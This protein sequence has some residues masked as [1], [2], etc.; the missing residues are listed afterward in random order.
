MSIHSSHARESLSQGH[1]RPETLSR[2]STGL[3]IE[4]PEPEEEP[5]AK[6]TP[7]A[8]I[9]DT[10]LQIVRWLG[11]GG[12][13]A[14]FEVRHL[15]IDRHFAIKLLHQS[16]SVA[17][18]RRFRREAK[19]IGNLG[20]P[21]IVEVFDF[22]EL[23]D[24]RLMYLM[25]LVEGRSLHEHQREIGALPLAAVI[26]LARQLCKGL[27]DA[28]GRG[29]IHRDIKPEN[30]M[31][32]TDADGRERVKIVDFGLAGLLAEPNESS[33]AGTPTYMS[34][35]QCKGEPADARTDLYSLGVT[36]YELACGRLPFTG[37]TERQL[38]EAHVYQQPE[39]PSAKLGD[40]SRALPAA[41]DELVLRCMAKDP[42]D[43]FANAAE[44]EAALIELQIGRR[45]RTD[46]DELPAPKVDEKRRQRLEQ[47]LTLL[48]EDAQRSRRKR[49]F[50]GAALA[51]LVGLSAAV[52]WIAGAESR[53]EAA[54]QLEAELHALREQ[55][56]E[57]AQAGR[58]IY[59]LVEQPEDETAYRLLQKLEAL[60][61]PQALEMGRQLRSEI[62][63][64]LVRLGDAYWNREGGESYAREYYA[65][66]QLF[67][68]DEPHA[69]QRSGLSPARAEILGERAATGEFE[70]YELEAAEPLVALAATDEQ[71]VIAALDALDTSRLS[72]TNA[73]AID[74]LRGVD[75]NDQDR[76]MLAVRHGGAPI[77]GEPISS[78]DAATA[79]EPAPAN[80]AHDDAKPEPI[81]GRDRS[82]AKTLVTSGKAAYQTGD[83][84][85]AKRA[86]H[87]ALAADGSNLEAL[88]G[89][90]RIHFDRGDFKDALT[91]AKKALT[92]R[93][94]RGDL[95]LYV[96]DSC[97]KVLDYGCARSHY[98][99]AAEAGDSRAPARLRMLDD[100]L[101]GSKGS[102]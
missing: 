66:A 18:A 26:G 37:S 95:N 60:G 84:D 45:L 69:R 47:G 29:V 98:Q 38:R 61:S 85:E 40:E 62:A 56:R 43:R 16:Q 63:A 59:P 41:F 17:R 90:H 80:E 39:P 67:Q 96:G 72:A 36:L 101:G 89:L 5:P 53:A 3:E 6:L 23:P 52:G 83:L 33:R 8:I 27:A 22:K 64:D 7:G 77:I 9:P 73:A 1:T 102:P 54:A 31:L 32:T 50:L 57:A 25:E 82:T 93:P 79:V 19:T 14:V 76:V 100:R 2:T 51:S 81:A 28:H 24:G 74:R 86:F 88:I 20:S 44:L 97:M 99:R 49:M 94:K 15:D 35:E 71:S 58:W 92:L 75:H 46:W 21:W 30:V 42:N 91:Y 34:P 87:R 4:D 12:M 11:Q 70:T 68:P 65:Q 55:I 10:R 48:R 13:G 78:Q